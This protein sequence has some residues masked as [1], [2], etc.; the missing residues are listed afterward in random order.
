MKPALTYR[1]VIDVLPDEVQSVHFVTLRRLLVSGIYHSPNLDYSGGGGRLVTTRGRLLAK[2]FT[3][4]G[5][6]FT[7]VHPA[8]TEVAGTGRRSC[9][10]RSLRSR[11]LPVTRQL[12]LNGQESSCL[13]YTP[14][15][16]WLVWGGLQVNPLVLWDTADWTPTPL[17]GFPQAV[18]CLALSHDGR[19]LL[20]G[21]WG[22]CI[23]V[24]D[25]DRWRVTA[26]WQSPPRQQGLGHPAVRALQLSPDGRTLYAGFSGPPHLLAFSFP[27]FVAA[28][29]LDQESRVYTAVLLPDGLTLATGDDAAEVKLW[30]VQTG[31][32]LSRYRTAGGER[33]AIDLHT[34][35]A[36]RK[37]V[38]AAEVSSLAVSPDG[39][40]LAAGDF[41]GRVHLLD[42]TP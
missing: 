42:L 25:T 30:D 24:W 7:A 2:G 9:I 28:V 15:G 18:S 31:A 21:G 37:P 33:R 16:R 20:V 8:G 17:T 38:A 5:T 26:E 12:M 35:E 36:V 19:S 14:D 6:G 27:E 10:I 3:G 23:Q 4:W 1:R 39:R 29:P 32:L 22:G 13:L 40:A 34:G 41:I 11:R